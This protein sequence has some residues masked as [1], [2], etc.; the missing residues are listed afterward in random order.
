MKMLNYSW[1]KWGFSR[2]LVGVNAES[3][4]AA[5]TAMLP[6][7]GLAEEEEMEEEH[8]DGDMKV[9]VMKVDVAI[10]VVSWMRY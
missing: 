4:R 1:K 9:K 8:M 5:S 3:I 2:L 10:C 7:N 6:K